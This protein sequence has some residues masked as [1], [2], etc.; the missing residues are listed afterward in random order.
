MQINFNYMRMDDHEVNILYHIMFIDIHM[1]QVLALIPDKV[2][3]TYE[4]AYVQGAHWSSSFFLTA[5]RA[6]VIFIKGVSRYGKVVIL[7]APP[8]GKQWS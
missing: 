2:K 4:V 1:K 8:G 3:H 6:T 7:S 5:E